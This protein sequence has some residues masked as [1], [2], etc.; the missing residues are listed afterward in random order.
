MQMV[1]RRKKTYRT[2]FSELGFGETFYDD[3]GTAPYPYAWRKIGRRHYDYGP[4]PLTGEMEGS[5]V[6]N[7]STKRVIKVM[8]VWDQFR[9]VTEH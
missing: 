7:I 9:V 1:Y 2:R 4:N 3:D 6:A 5:S 8:P